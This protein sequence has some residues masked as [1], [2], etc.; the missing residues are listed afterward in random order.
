MVEK[1]QI[2]EIGTKV[3]PGQYGGI[4]RNNCIVASRDALSPIQ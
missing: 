3:G 2:A 4:Q 1:L